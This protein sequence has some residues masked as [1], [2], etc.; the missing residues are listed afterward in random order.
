MSRKQGQSFSRSSFPN[1][2]TARK[3]S[4]NLSWNWP[5]KLLVRVEKVGRSGRV[6]VDEWGEEFL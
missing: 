5:P 4:S 2:P 1:S 6:P 3:N